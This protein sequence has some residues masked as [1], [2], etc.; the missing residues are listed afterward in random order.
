MAIKV[1][2]ECTGHQ[3][4]DVSSF[5]L[6][7][8]SQHLAFQLVQVILQSL[9]MLL[10]ITYHDLGFRIS[11]KH[12]QVPNVLGTLSPV[13]HQSLL[14]TA[15]QQQHWHLQYHVLSQQALYKC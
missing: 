6:K 7:S 1:A 12:G 15:R 10:G 14:A 11:E 9:G 4:L 5:P 13:F 8:H 3:L 2:L